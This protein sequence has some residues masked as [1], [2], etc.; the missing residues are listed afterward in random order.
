MI[1][2]RWRRLVR[3]GLVLM[4]LLG[5]AG[6]ACGAPDPL[7]EN[8]SALGAAPT[9]RILF[10]QNGDIYMWNGSTTQLTHV[11]DASYPRWSADGNR[12][13]FVRTGDAFSDLY[14]ANAD[15]SG[16]E[17]L[18]FYQPLLQPGTEAYIQEA[19][20]ALDP[21]WSPAGDAIAFVSDRNTLKNFLWLMPSPG[22]NSYQVQSSTYNGEN[23]E[24]P[25][26]SPDGQ[27]IVFAQRTTGNSDLERWT[28]LWIVD[29]NTER[30][31][32]LVEST[33]GAYDPAWSPDGRWIAYTGRTGAE[34]DIWVVPAEGGTPI[35]LTNLH[36]VRAP[37]WSPDGSWI[38][39]LQVDGDSF[40]AVAA[41]FSVGDD[42]MPKL[43]EPQELFKGRGIDA[44]SGL[45]WRP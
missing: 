10:A 33:E 34:N 8:E 28:Q 36:N 37:T 26:F 23:V 4:M 35:R 41:P 7:L 18:T 40:K 11:G 16:M 14:M 44:S 30:L 42:G 3:A 21:V 17:Q 24:H 32:P 9:G 45:S 12:F 19:M 22:E 25:D 29:L 1:L 5:L 27:R 6:I 31:T 15:G 43:G 38:A 39:F 13:V 2:Q 20:W